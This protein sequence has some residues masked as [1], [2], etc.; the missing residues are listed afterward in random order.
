MID[1]FHQAQ[2]NLL[3]RIQKLKTH[4]NGPLE[5]KNK[6]IWAC[7]FWWMDTCDK[8]D[9]VDKKSDANIQVNFGDLELNQVTYP[10][11]WSRA[12]LFARRLMR[13]NIELA[14]PSAA[15]SKT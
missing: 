9:F 2:S 1:M 5:A 12:N 7:R 13:T 15:E 6:C 10:W 4:N 14:A 3:D 8:M 11:V